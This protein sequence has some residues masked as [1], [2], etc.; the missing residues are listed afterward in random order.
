MDLRYSIRI[1]ARMETLYVLQCED[2]TYYVGK[3]KDVA[4]RFKEHTS[5]N[6]SAWTSVHKP[7]RIV[8]TRPLRNDHDENNLTKDYMKKY[9]VENVRG[10]SYSQITLSHQTKSV[11][12]SEIRGNTD[13]CFKCGEKGH[14]ARDCEE[15]VVWECD[16]CDEEFE[17]EAACV[18]HE[19]SCGGQVDY[20]TT[21]RSY[22]SCYKC[23]RRGHWAPDCYARTH[24]SGYELD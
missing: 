7:L 22:G 9:G 14:F 8:E 17:T 11:L 5:G 18:R 2:G 4:K 24:V 3:S 23:G 21:A 20:R 10:G 13:A 16:H 19:K 15:E 1:S 12:E 6:G